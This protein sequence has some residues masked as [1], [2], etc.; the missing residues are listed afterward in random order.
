MEI[1]KLREEIF[2][3]FSLIKN[4]SELE[5]FRV[6]YLGKKGLLTSYLKELKNLPLEERKSLGRELNELKEK[7]EEL[8][9]QK[10]R[11]I[12]FQEEDREL[13][14]DLT[15]TGK[16]RD[17]G[18]LHPLTQVI[19][20]LSQIFIRLGFEVV[21][22]PEIES[23]YYNFT[24]LNIPEWHP[25]R[26]MQATFY[27]KNGA[28]LRTHTSP[29]QI[30]AM[31]ERTPPLRIIAPGKVYR[32]DADI[33]HSPMFHQI[34][35]L[36]V[37][38]EVSFSDLKGILTYFAQETFGEKTKVRFRPSYFPFT[39]PSLE[40]DIGC[41]ICETKGCRVCGGS[42]WL[43]ILG[44]GMVHP[45]VFKAVNYD[46]SKWQGFA[47]GLGIERVAMIK[48]EIEDIRLF[49]ENHFLFLNSFK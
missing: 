41:V 1:E 10:E 40:M 23:D 9:K 3:E 7:L 8:L 31:L 4:L 15:L 49:F 30:R 36:M 33:R 5:A 24:A 38:E 2:E 11:E 35:G 44:A 32:C 42:G 16:K 6:K 26:D 43:E 12:L 37:D 18:N 17:L 47:F 48:Y 28:L 29:M 22:G 39:E 46:I 13:E 45:E 20:E 25:A 21:T 34:E 14:I 27:L 19:E